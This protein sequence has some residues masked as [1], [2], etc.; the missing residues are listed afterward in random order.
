M[1]KAI[2]FITLISLASCK[3]CYECVGQTPEKQS[4]KEEFCGSKSEL[5]KYKNAKKENDG[6]VIC[7]EILD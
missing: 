2:L 3:K 7:A 1:K 5:T 6:L 4:F